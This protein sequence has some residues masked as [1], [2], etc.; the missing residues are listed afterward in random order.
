MR[1]MS[2]CR[3]SGIQKIKNAFPY[4]LRR[5]LPEKI[6]IISLAMQESARLNRFYLK[7][8]TPANVLSFRYGADYG[9]ILLCPEVIRREAREARNPQEYQMT[10]MIVHG[11]IHLAGVHHERS[12]AVARR[13]EKLEKDILAHFFHS[14]RSGFRLLAF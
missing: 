3:S 14:D 5:K 13:F 1:K 7:K 9:E 2:T 4:F 8:N 12:K 11:M 10:W 6:K